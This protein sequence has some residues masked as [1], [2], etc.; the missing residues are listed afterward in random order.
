MSGGP[1][2]PGGTLVCGTDTS[3]G[4]VGSII[5]GCNPLGRV[6]LAVPPRATGRPGRPW[7]GGGS[8]AAGK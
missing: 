4:G 3:G 1:P 7:G 8:F 5:E 2:A 6:T